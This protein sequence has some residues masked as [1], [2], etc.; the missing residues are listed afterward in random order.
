MKRKP[1][2][3][4]TLFYLNVGNAARR[5]SVQVLTPVTVKTVGRKYFTCEPSE[6]QYR[7]KTTY[8]IGSWEQ[9]TEYCR[10]QQL[11]ET[12]KEWEDEKEASEIHAALRA[13]F[14]H[15]SRCGVPLETL[16]AIK[17]LLANA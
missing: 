12:T 17:S 5:G 8:K 13:E 6:G 14:N 11:Y 2:L 3:G 15:Y 7:P 10:D 4:E 9:K 16:R 1:I